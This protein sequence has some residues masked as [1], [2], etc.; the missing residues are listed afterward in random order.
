[1]AK[2]EWKYTFG[3]VPSRRLGLSLGVDLIPSKTCS[4]DCTYCQL[5]R[6]SASTMKIQEYVPADDVV[7]E[8][9][10]RMLETATFDTLTFSGSGEPTLHSSMG[11]II[12]EAK[13]LT[14]RMVAVITNGSLLWKEQIRTALIEADI[15]L[16]SLDAGCAGTF[17][18]MNRPH[19]SLDFDT[20][21]KG[22][23]KFGQ[24]RR[25]L[26]WLE[27]M[28]VEGVNDSDAELR[29]MLPIV[30]R[31]APDRVQLNAPVRPG[32][33]QG[34]GLVSPE[35]LQE[36]AALFGPKAEVIADF[37]DKLRRPGCGDLETGLLSMLSRRPCTASDIA[38]ALGAAP[39]DVDKR[40]STMK[41]QGL[42]RERHLG[43]TVFYTAKRDPGA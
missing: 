3:P 19:A 5:G 40:L 6:T 22:L 20:M 4:Y 26:L 30:E 10:E 43:R 37:Q 11:W 42:I 39:E 16:P 12:H 25:G 1:M 23:V 15:V 35:R 17:A 7:T 33:D 13:Q 14:D 9:G 41:Q 18:S 32:A 2:R 28:I 38:S 27:V 21:V 34:L 31:I 24:E 8:L 29:K 36:I